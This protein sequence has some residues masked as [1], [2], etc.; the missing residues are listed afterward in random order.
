MSG[1]EQYK[2]IEK[3]VCFFSQ[4][5]SEWPGLTLNQNGVELL[6]CNSFV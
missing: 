3:K 6:N 2:M 5:I 1:F 4:T